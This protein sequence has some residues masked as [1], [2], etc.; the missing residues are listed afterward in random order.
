MSVVNVHAAKAGAIVCPRALQGG[1]DGHICELI[2]TDIPH[3]C[4]G[5]TKSG[6]SE[7]GVPTQHAFQGEGAILQSKQAVQPSRQGC[8]MLTSLPPRSHAHWT[9]SASRDS[10]AQK[11]Q[12]TFPRSH[13][14]QAVKLESSCPVIHN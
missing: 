5:K 13:S 10:E 7:P 12:G 8:E 3:C 11:R 4:H 1:P 14:E 9:G 6:V 2:L